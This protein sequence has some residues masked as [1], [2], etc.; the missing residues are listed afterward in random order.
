MQTLGLMLKS[1]GPDALRA[2]RL[3]QSFQRF[4]DDALHLTIVVPPADLPDFLHLA[5]DTVDVMDE[6]PFAGYLVDSPVAGVSPGY[7]NQQIV[8][9]AFWELDRYENYLVLDSDAVFI[10][11]FRAADFMADDRTPYSIL[12]EDNDLKCDPRYFREHWQGREVHLRR[13]QELVGLNDQRLLTCHNHQV[14]NRQV[15]QSLKT[16]FMGPR[17][18]SYRNLIQEAPYEFSWYNFWLQRSK[19]IPIEIREPWFKMLHHEGHHMEMAL[20]GLTLED[21]AR[22]YVGLVVNSSFARE[23]ADLS[24]DEPASRTVA[25]YVGLGTLASAL[26]RRVAMLPSTLLHRT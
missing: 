14:F 11:P 15:L 20:R 22:G 13:I 7:A 8:K 5:G 4:N 2:E 3:V 24:P 10:R 23:W 1:Y 9:L 17:G 26:G 25:R 18:W 21:Y 6:T 16:E 19:V 12:V